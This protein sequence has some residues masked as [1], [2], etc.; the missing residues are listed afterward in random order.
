MFLMCEWIISLQGQD[1]S[2]L[3]NKS[4]VNKN[5]PSTLHVVD[6]RYNKFNYSYIN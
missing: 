2:L 5:M 1:L 6:I 3:H 4:Q